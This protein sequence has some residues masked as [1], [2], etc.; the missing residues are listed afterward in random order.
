MEQRKLI[1]LGKSSYAITLPKNWITRNKLEKGDVI[2]VII[3][4]DGSLGVHPSIDVGDYI[5]GIQ[6]DVAADEG[7]DS[8]IRRIIGCYLDG[9]TH[10][11]LRSEKIFTSN[12]QTMIRDILGRLYMM[13]I[14]S[15]SSRILLETLVDESRASVHS[16]VERM[17]V[18][19]YSMCRD[20]LQ[21]LKD[22]DNELAKSV[23]S[24]EQD[25]D[26]LMLLLLR[27]IRSAA[28][29]PALANQLKLDALDCLD[30]QSLVH[31]IEEVADHALD[32]AHS[33][34]FLIDSE[35][36][37]PDKVISVLVEAGD[38]AFESYNAAV[39]S[40]ISKDL[41][42]TNEIIDNKKAITELYREITPMPHFQ[43]SS[44]SLLSNIIRIRESIMKIG[45]HAADIAELTIDRRYK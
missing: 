22:N 30:Y 7:G 43:A 16:G 19:T 1:T 18:I 37:I 8:I 17:H 26:Q 14:E 45:D 3:K 35:V 2:S 5:R 41:E 40:Y 13:I 12:Q 20:T 9:Y 38:I 23:I 10:I 31:I 42:H 24:L 27:S 44:S 4:R 36:E 39:E 15:E 29:N 28:V 21:S 25:V 32:M 6:L 33:V 11:E 34:I